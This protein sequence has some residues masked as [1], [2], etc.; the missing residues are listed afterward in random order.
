MKLLPFS[1]ICYL[2]ISW[3]SYGLLSSGIQWFLLILTYLGRIGLYTYIFNTQQINISTNFRAIL[4]ISMSFQFLKSIN[5][6]YV[7]LQEKYSPNQIQT[8]RTLTYQLDLILET[9][10][11]TC[12][13]ITQEIK[14]VLDN[15]RLAISQQKLDKIWIIL[16][17]I[18]NFETLEMEPPSLQTIHNALSVVNMITFLTNT[19]A[20]FAKSVTGETQITIRN[21][22]SSK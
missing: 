3:P 6:S 14:R 22:V 8:I 18:Q 1:N 9:L 17:E 19:L 11:T 10:L 20:M 15:W 7:L 16:V 13:K 21:F 2:T 4:K 5:N 12:K